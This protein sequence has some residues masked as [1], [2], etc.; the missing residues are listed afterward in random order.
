MPSM[1]RLD[2]NRD[3]LVLGLRA[4]G[5]PN[6]EIAEVFFFSASQASQIGVATRRMIRRLR[7]DGV[8]GLVEKYGNRTALIGGIHWW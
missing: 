5:V 7:N 3:L 2:R 4:E 8:F 6:K 1:T